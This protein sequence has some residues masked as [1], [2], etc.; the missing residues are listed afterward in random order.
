MKE[1][2]IL[3]VEDHKELR[4][5]LEESLSF[6]TNVIAVSNGIDCLETLKKQIPDLIL[7]DIM[8]PFPLDGFSILR[9]L[10][11]DP[12]LSAIPVILMSALNSDDKISMGLE[13]GAND[14]LVKPLKIN[15]LL[16]KVKNLVGIKKEIINQ[17][18]KKT[19]LKDEDNDLPSFEMTFKKNFSS[20][21]DELF[22]NNTLTVQDLAEKLSMSI[23]TLER[24]VIRFYN[25]T[26]QKYI[27]RS[28]LMK[29]EMMLRQN[30]G[31]IKDI[32]YTT[33]FNSEPYFCACFKKE[34]GKSPLAFK[35]D[36]GGTAQR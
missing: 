18:E 14:Y 29:A 1:T 15:E 3:L 35:K 5:S 6:T 27:I 34:Y 12:K 23:S 25:M 31:S 4:E 33:G 30:L 21:V 20:A 2:S 13:L 9:I 19:V 11:N 17:M 36:V 26:P 22:D 8:L 7:L 16:L 32:A 24:W 28:R 10:K